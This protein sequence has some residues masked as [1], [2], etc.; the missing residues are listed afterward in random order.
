ME[1]WNGGLP[2]TPWQLRHS[3]HAH[4]THVTPF[5]D[6]PN[7]CSRSSRPSIKLQSNFHPKLSPA[8]G[9]DRAAEAGRWREPASPCKALAPLSNHLPSKRVHP[10]QHPAKLDRE[11]GWTGKNVPGRDHANPPQLQTASHRMPRD[12]YVGGT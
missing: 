5:P 2:Q 6:Q 11:D 8:L 9:R 1:R 10:L 3:G 7:H 4:T 12:D